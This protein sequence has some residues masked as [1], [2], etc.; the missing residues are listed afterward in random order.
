[1]KEFFTTMRKPIARAASCSTWLNCGLPCGPVTESPSTLPDWTPAALA[2]KQALP[3]G[4]V[5]R[6]LEPVASAVQDAHAVHRAPRSRTAKR[7]DRSQSKPS[8]TMRSQPKYV[9][10][11]TAAAGGSLAASTSCR[12]TSARCK[13]LSNCQTRSN[14][15]RCTREEYVSCT[16]STVTRSVCDP[17]ES[18]TA[19]IWKKGR[20]RGTREPAMLAAPSF[21]AMCRSSS[22]GPV[23]ALSVSRSST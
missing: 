16:H 21:T 5:A 18:W 14:P 19:N 3:E 17:L 8:P 23:V 4:E 12:C 10:A 13:P 15:N 11:L 2:G 1:M 9:M 20:G 6:Q 7:L 22:S